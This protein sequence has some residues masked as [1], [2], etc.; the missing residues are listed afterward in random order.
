MVRRAG[1]GIS[2]ENRGLPDFLFYN[3]IKGNRIWGQEYIVHMRGGLNKNEIG[4]LI[5]GMTLIR[6]AELQGYGL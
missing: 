5:E 4:K 2:T 1:F 6:E 3:G